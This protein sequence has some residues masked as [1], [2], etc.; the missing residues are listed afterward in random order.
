MI[1]NDYYIVWKNI[2]LFTNKYII[3]FAK[4]EKKWYNK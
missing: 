1:L 2:G 4:N 3:L